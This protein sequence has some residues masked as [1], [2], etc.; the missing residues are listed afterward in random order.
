MCCNAIGEYLPLN[1]ILKG[2]HLYSN[3]C[4]NGPPGATY[5]TSES[6]WMEGEQFY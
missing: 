6:G 1:F 5:D 4:V 3:Y 2:K